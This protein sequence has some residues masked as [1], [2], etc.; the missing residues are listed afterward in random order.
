LVWFQLLAILGTLSGKKAKDGTPCSLWAML[1][2][3]KEVE[4][5]E[6]LT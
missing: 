6:E 4:L 1:L 5:L 2:Y 3:E